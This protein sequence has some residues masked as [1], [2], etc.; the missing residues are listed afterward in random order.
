MSKELKIL[1]SSFLMLIFIWSTHIWLANFYP[2]NI[3]VSDA[4]LI[5]YPP[6][7]IF[8]LSLF[9]FLI[10]KKEIAIG[11]IIGGIIYVLGLWFN[12]WWDISEMPCG[13]KYF[14]N[15]LTNCPGIK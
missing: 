2:D 14:F 10:G 9:F 3:Y 6:L 13:T 5:F 11:V 7:L 8:T 4:T 1:L 12:I 15:L